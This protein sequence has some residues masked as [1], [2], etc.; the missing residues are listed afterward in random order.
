MFTTEG[1]KHQPIV[2]SEKPKPDVTDVPKTL[3]VLL[4]DFWFLIAN[5]NVV[6][7]PEGSFD[8]RNICLSV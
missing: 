5:S 7:N 3:V 8:H 4:I 1:G 2:Q 6:V